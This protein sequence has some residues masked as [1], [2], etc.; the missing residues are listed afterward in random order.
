MHCPRSLLATPPSSDAPDDRSILFLYCS[1]I[2]ELQL[3][4]QYC[5]IIE[6]NKINTLAS[7]IYRKISVYQK[8]FFPAEFF[9]KSRGCVLYTGTIVFL[10][11]IFFFLKC[12][13]MPLHLS[14]SPSSVTHGVLIHH[15]ETR[16]TLPVL[17]NFCLDLEEKFVCHL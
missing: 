1:V 12:R 4:I 14:L 9:F 13:F 10:I 8:H 11:I 6:S 15:S 3:S 7:L 16:T 17:P 5:L 2:R